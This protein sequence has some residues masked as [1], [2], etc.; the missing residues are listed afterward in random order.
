MGSTARNTPLKVGLGV[1]I[2]VFAALLALAWLKVY[3]KNGIGID[4]LG[5]SLKGKI[6]NVQLAK[7]LTG[8]APQ[9]AELTVA[10]RSELAA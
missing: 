2:P 4:E 6:G 9:P 1:G 10:S 3:K 8:Q 5:S 7:E